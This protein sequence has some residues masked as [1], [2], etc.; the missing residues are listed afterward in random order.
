M[1]FFRMLLDLK[2]VLEET[3]VSEV[4]ERN[5]WQPNEDD[6]ILGINTPLHVRIKV[7]HVGEKFLL[8]GKVNGSIMVRCDRCLDPFHWE[9][10]SAF[11]VFLVSPRPGKD[12]A[13][14]ELL[15]ED[16]EVD[17]IHGE[18]IDLDHI[19]KEQ[20]YLA[21][22]MKSICRDACLGL[23]PV[24]GANLNV[25]RCQCNQQSIKPAF[26]KLKDFKFEGA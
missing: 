26:Q 13:E 4:L 9:L 22:P 2:G 1:G 25:Q 3:E 12:Q 24:C 21:L 5:W 18:T 11:H 15:D 17:F 8:D 14:V 23:C 10:E 16:M 19:I 20:V 7:T 6:P